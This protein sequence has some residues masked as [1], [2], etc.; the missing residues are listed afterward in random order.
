MNKKSNLIRTFRKKIKILKKHN[1]L[2]YN[3]D[4]PEVTDFEY[5]SLKK[6]ITNLENKYKFLKELKLTNN[7]VGSPPQN[8]FKKIKHLHPMLSLSNVF[9]KDGMKDFLKRLKIF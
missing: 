7:L 3:L 1:H 4:N 8:K 2:Y 6:E 9:D 5:D